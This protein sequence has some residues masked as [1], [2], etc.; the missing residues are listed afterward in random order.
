MHKSHWWRLSYSWNLTFTAF[1]PPDYFL[2]NLIL[3]IEFMRTNLRYI[4]SVRSSN[5]TREISLIF[6]GT[7]KFSEYGNLNFGVYKSEFSW[8]LQCKI[9]NKDRERENGY[10]NKFTWNYQFENGLTH[11][12]FFNIHKCIWFAMKIHD[13]SN[14]K[15]VWKGQLLLS[16]AFRF[17]GQRT[18][19][20]RR[21][22]NF[23]RK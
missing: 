15:W 11:F 13:H 18:I 12:Y 6:N 21:R 16:I 14:L 9:L 17:Q 10:I 4:S 7:L 19:I 20:I 22:N 3:I 1:I 2:S 8:M 5:P 23:S